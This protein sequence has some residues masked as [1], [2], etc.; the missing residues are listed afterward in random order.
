MYIDAE[1]AFNARI[2][3]D[4][5]LLDYSNFPELEHKILELFDKKG[6]VGIFNTCCVALS[7]L[8][9]DFKGALKQSDSSLQSMQN[10]IDSLKRQHD[11]A[12]IRC[13]RKYFR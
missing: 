4:K 2:K 12:R 1:T 11:D 10:M 3:N 5:E 6:T 7:N 8:I 9:N 13:R